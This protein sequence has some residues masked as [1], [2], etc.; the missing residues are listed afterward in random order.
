MALFDFEKAY[1]TLVKD[2][3]ILKLSALNFT[4]SLIKFLISYINNIQYFETKSLLEELPRR[5]GMSYLQLPSTV[6]LMVSSLHVQR[7]LSNALPSSLLESRFNNLL[8]SQQIPEVD[9]NTSV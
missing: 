2:G 8:S 6:S 4:L 9:F 5:D 3:I 1:V 7:N